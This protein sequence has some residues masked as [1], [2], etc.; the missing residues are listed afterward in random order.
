MSFNIS[1]LFFRVSNW[2]SLLVIAGV[3]IAFAVLLFH[4]QE[5]LT[6]TSERVME[7][8]QIDLDLSRHKAEH[9]QTY[10]AVLQGV[11]IPSA[12]PLSSNAWIQATQTLVA[13]H[14][15][16]LQELKPA[17]QRERS[18][19]KSTNLLLIAESRV[20]DLINFLYR[21]AQAGDLVYVERLQI[22]EAPSDSEL[23]RIQATLSQMKSQK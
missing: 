1:A 8:Y 10:Q 9:V 7:E 4:F 5:G 17:H 6:E 19:G 21:I 23:V 11:Q 18:G 2:R 15:L 13:E 16:S 12:Q 20:A 22:S 3:S 14:Q